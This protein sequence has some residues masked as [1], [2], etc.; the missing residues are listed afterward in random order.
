M[1][2]PLPLPLA[3]AVASFL[4]SGCGVTQVVDRGDDGT[5]ILI[6]SP[7]PDRG[8]LR[9][10]A[11]THGV[12]TVVNLRGESPDKDWFQEEQKGVADIGARWVQLKVDGANA[13]SPEVVERFMNL[14]EDPANWPVLVHCQGG[15]HRTGLV[16]ALY[17]IQYQGWSPEAAVAEMEDL[18]FNWTLRD[19]ERVK[20][21]LRAYQ[22]VDR[23]V[24]RRM[25]AARSPS[26]PPP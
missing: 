2:T 15:V 17:R 12:K 26:G 18:W 20:E 7:Q 10:L 21:Y 1:R 9:E 23:R 14:V 16:C 25:L 4:L 3:L 24:P 11:A 8:D 22:P 13:P 5:P 19:R 6:R